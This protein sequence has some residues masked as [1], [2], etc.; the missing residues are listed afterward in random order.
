MSTKLV[1][2]K[3]MFSIRNT[4]QV[5]R[6]GVS[7]QIRMFLGSDLELS[8]PEGPGA[9][10][11]SWKTRLVLHN[12]VNNRM[13]AKNKTLK[14]LI[15]H[16][17][18]MC[19]TVNCIFKWGTAFCHS[20]TLRDVLDSHLGRISRSNLEPQT[21]FFVQ[22]GWLRL[23]EAGMAYVKSNTLFWEKALSICNTSQFAPY[24]YC[25]ANL[26]PPLWKTQ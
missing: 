11:T 9:K 1:I 8:F 26:L 12:K 7:L 3:S 6:P 4:T 15:H 20:L 23:G 24:V 10:T 18:G 2:S 22:R 16:G 21:T 19:S 14:M 5:F 17:S 13:W 25:P